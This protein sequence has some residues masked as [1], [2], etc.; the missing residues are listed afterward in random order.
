ME[1]IEIEIKITRA[2]AVKEN[3]SRVTSDGNL[4]KRKGRSESPAAGSNLQVSILA[5]IHGL[6]AAL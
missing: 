2:G 1:C 5:F 3:I 6:C 4:K